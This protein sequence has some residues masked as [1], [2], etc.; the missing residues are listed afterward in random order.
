MQVVDAFHGI[1]W[2]G[3]KDS[4]GWKAQWRPLR[5]LKAFPGFSFISLPQVFSSEQDA[6][7]WV[8]DHVE[9]ILAGRR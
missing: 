3:V 7:A 9:S 8:R 5:A 1:E 4:A 2:R 6:V